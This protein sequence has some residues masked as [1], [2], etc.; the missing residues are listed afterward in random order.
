[1]AEPLS[2]SSGEAGAPPEVT[3]G[4]Y[5]P[6]SQVTH[7]PHGALYRARRGDGPAVFLKAVKP[8]ASSAAMLDRFDACAEAV[9]K[10]KHA[11]V[12]R[13]IE[14]GTDEA[15]G[16]RFAA[17][18]A[19]GTETLK[20][21]VEERGRLSES[22]AAAIAVQIANAMD[23]IYGLKLIHG[24]VKPSHIVVARGG[25]AQ[26]GMLG[27]A[28]PV[29]D[30]TVGTGESARFMSPEVTTSSEVDIRADMYSLGAV[31]YYMLTG[32]AP[33]ADKSPKIAVEAHKAG[34]ATW[35]E[36][37]ARA[38]SDGLL[39]V[40]A[41]MMAKSPKERY[42]TPTELVLDLHIVKEGQQPIIA[43]SAP[44]QSTVAA[45]EAGGGARRAV[46]RSTGTA[47][48]IKAKRVTGGTT[49]G[50]RVVRGE[51]PRRGTN[52]KLVAA[53]TGGLV[54]LLIGLALIL[55]G[56]APEP[57]AENMPMPTKGGVPPPR[58]VVVPSVA[59]S[60][61]EAND[62]PLAGQS[63][64]DTDGEDAQALFDETKAYA[65]GKADDYAGILKRYQRC[66]VLAGN[67]P[68][69]E[70]IDAEVSNVTARRLEA[71][72]AAFEKASRLSRARAREDNYDHAIKAFDDVP[73]ALTAVLPERFASEIARVK[74]NGDEKVSSSL[75]KVSAH[76]DAGD[77]AAARIELAALDSIR[78]A[79]GRKVHAA[80]EQALLKRV[81]D[82]EQE[83]RE[84]A[85]ASARKELPGLLAKFDAFVDEGE[86]G[87]AHGLMETE[88]QRRD[89]V[90]V[91]GTLGAARNVAAALM[92][93]A[94]AMREAASKLVGKSAELRT[95]KGMRKGAVTDV[96][97]GG[98]VLEIPMIVNGKV[99]GN[100]RTTIAWRDL[101]DEE[102]ARLLVEY[103]AEDPSSLAVGMAMVA[104]AMGDEAAAGTELGRAGEHQFA[105]HVRSRIEA[106]KV[107]EEDAKAA[108]LWR[109]VE[110]DLA[111]GRPSAYQIRRLGKLIDEFESKYGKSHFAH[112]LGDKLLAAKERLARLDTSRARPMRIPGDAKAFGGN[113]YRVFTEALPW[114]QARLACLKLGG[115]LVS[116]GSARARAGRKCGWD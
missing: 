27:V 38:T 105:P 57:G 35:P 69:G 28:E 51:A 91:V 3:I 106:L 89:L 31:I 116:I 56:G 109:L 5:R 4:G 102:Q 97:A 23:C 100:T 12:C 67:T 73:E 77:T 86:Y 65:K 64:P 13:L 68:L 115:H 18:E 54:V 47:T 71:A 92:E 25:V 1:V 59:P 96:V 62:G 75:A 32:A 85:S 53:G 81:R 48:K 61:A 36:D 16:L 15:T 70:L 52:L 58:A 76:L 19:A 60:P 29:A 49:K 41:R 90:P 114:E 55:G 43:A 33:F 17:Y 107:G 6:L 11:N 94:G 108:A 93:R 103:E 8:C 74:K 30:A 72:D 87:S 42:R 80:R 10:A 78:H 9:A 88:M 104:L 44:S 34:S 37:V 99:A 66:R 22:E 21:I 98:I 45:P 110:A 14:H 95:R 39:R 50:G 40:A 26:L 101:G 111:R 79:S 46:K 7:T 82:V 63:A 112:E 113:K 2:E 24:D 20:D 83:K 84:A